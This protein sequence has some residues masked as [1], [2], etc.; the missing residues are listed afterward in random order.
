MGNK[1]HRWPLR[2][3]IKS[4]ISI[5]WEK[6][7]KFDSVEKQKLLKSEFCESLKMWISLLATLAICSLIIVKCSLR[8]LQK[9]LKNDLDIE[10]EAH[11]AAVKQHLLCVV[12]CV[13][14]VVIN[15]GSFFLSV[16]ESSALGPYAQ[17][18][19]QI[20]NN[21]HLAHEWKFFW[22]LWQRWII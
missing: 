15:E 9:I 1:C 10:D 3:Y 22:Y 17:N 4:N 21:A 12:V 2:H 7:R 11:S 16:V 6:V 5:F 13:V 18:F 8:G 14:L 19:F 20:S